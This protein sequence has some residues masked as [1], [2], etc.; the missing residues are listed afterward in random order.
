MGDHYNK[1]KIGDRYEDLAAA[2][3]SRHGYHILERNFRS[4]GGELDIVAKKD[5]VLVIC[6]VKYRGTGNAGYA[7]E[8]VGYRKQKK[9]SQMAGLY[10][11]AR[12]YGPQTQVRFDVIGFDG[13][14]K[15]THIENAF[16]YC[17]GDA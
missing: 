9:I 10:L 15:M 7:L 6:E 11:I 3:L 4:R 12:G 13:D 5:G 1:K 2:Y 8:A 14:G 17:Y 16:P